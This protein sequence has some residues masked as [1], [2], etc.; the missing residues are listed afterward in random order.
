MDIVSARPCPPVPLHHPI[1]SSLC[2]IR[3]RQ[4]SVPTERLETLFRLKGMKITLVAFKG[5][6][7]GACRATARKGEKKRKRQRNGTRAPT[8]IGFYE[9]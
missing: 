3:C 2:V 6:G 5:P 7:K 9:T 4:C 1:P 8:G